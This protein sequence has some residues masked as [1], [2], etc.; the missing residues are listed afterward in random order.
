MQQEQP[1]VVATASFIATVD[2][3]YGAALQLTQGCSAVSGTCGGEAVKGQGRDHLRT[4][5]AGETND[6]HHTCA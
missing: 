5:L 6:I 1:I 4:T 2:G 3:T